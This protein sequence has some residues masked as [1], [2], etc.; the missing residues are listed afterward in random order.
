MCL[1]SATMRILARSGNGPKGD[2][3][4][5]IIAHELAAHEHGGDHELAII[6]GPETRLPIGYAAREWLRPMERCWKAR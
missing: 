4:Q 2:G 3:A 6:A 1:R 5:A